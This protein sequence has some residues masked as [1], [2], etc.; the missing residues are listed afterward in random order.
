MKTFIIAAFCLL[1]ASGAGAQ[2]RSR[3]IQDQS[4]SISMVR[5]GAGL[6]S[7]FGLLNPDNFLMKHTLSYSYLNAGGTGLSVASYTN[8]MFYQIADPLNVRMDI[9]L[10]GS[11]FGPTA[12]AD[13]NNL[14]KL[15]VSRVELNYQPWKDVFL[16]LQYRE[17]PYFSY[18][19]F[20]D[21]F[22]FGPSWGD[23]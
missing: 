23:R 9:T 15:Y 20:G 7:F 11:P 8:S 5:P 19:D 22:G 17:S 6:S 18:R 16:Q 12:G 10:Q 13:R 1:F 3:T 21:P 2:L 4:A 14:S